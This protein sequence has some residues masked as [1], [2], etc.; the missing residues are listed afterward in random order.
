M[1]RRILPLILAMLLIASAC[2]N[3]AKQNSESAQ[4]TSTTQPAQTTSGQA[5]T[6]PSSPSAPQADQSTAQQATVPTETAKATT[7]G[8][9]GK[10]EPSSLP[11]GEGESS[12][13]SARAA[14]R[15]VIPAGTAITVRLSN[16]VDSKTSNAGD[17]F[18]GSV[19]RAVVLNGQTLIPESS[20]VTGTVVESTHAGKLSGAGRLSVRLTHITIQ[21][22]P[23]AIST[24]TVSNSVQGKGKRSATMI[25]GGAGA[26]AL[27]GGL[28]GGGKGAAIGA[29]VGGGGGTAGSMLTGNKE[30]SFPAETALT[31]RLRQPLNL[32]GRSRAPDEQPTT[33]QQQPDQRP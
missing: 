29:L 14:Q 26:G 4:T 21:G 7:P 28:A 25:G 13:T 27:I 15:L 6:T 3:K 16:A 20:P 18:N 22:V 8:T 31:F 24:A 23:Y 1:P 10:S 12:G 5:S 11:Q 19:A 32:R 9:A 17:S 30:I 33:Q 2:T